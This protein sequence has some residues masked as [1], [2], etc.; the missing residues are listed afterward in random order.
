MEV[1]RGQTQKKQSTTSPSTF[2]YH[3]FLSR[4]NYFYIKMLL[5]KGMYCYRIFDK[6]PNSNYRE[7]QNCLSLLSK[8][9]CSSIGLFCWRPKRN[10]DNNKGTRVCVYSGCHCSSTKRLTWSLGKHS[11]GMAVSR[12]KSRIMGIGALRRGLSD[13]PP[14]TI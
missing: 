14:T 7:T 5:A 13:C 1:E 2:H 9:F 11:D 10:N 12:P 6:S 4:I 8:I 3:Y